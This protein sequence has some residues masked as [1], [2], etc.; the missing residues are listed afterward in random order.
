MSVIENTAEQALSVG[1]W[2][3]DPAHSTVEFRVKHLVVATVHGRFREFVGAIVADS[4][5]AVSASI[6]AASLETFSDERDAHLRSEDFFDV[7]RYPEI[8]FQSGEGLQFDGR[9]GLFALPGELTVKGITRPVELAGRIV[10]TGLDTDGR[11]RIGLV[12]DAEIDRTDYG[13]VWNRRLETGGVLV[14]NRVELAL[15]V[16]AVRVD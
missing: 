1:S 4:L 16:A 8:V 11:E 6:D 12:M 3:V 9:P 10:G 7:E 14:G 15:D 2:L 13:L 5:P